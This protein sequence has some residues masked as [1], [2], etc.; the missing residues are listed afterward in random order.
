MLEIVDILSKFDSCNDA[1]CTALYLYTNI[2]P[3][4][5]CIIVIFS[6]NASNVKPTINIRAFSSRNDWS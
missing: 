2:F 3:F 5:M 1:L 6:S 4:I